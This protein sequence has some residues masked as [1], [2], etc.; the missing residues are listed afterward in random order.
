[1][2]LSDISD[3]PVWHWYVRETNSDDPGANGTIAFCD[4]METIE[5]P[6]RRGCPPK[7]GFAIIS[8]EAFVP[9]LVGTV[10]QNTFRSLRR[11]SNDSG[12][13]HCEVRCEDK[14]GRENIL[15]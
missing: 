6:G 12:K 3:D 1:M 13:Y 5:Q 14:G 2:F 10:C 9:W 15:P 8:I 11:L 7:E 4:A